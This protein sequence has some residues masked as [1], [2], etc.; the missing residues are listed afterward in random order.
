[1]RSCGARSSSLLSG[2]EGGGV[3]VEWL[4]GTLEPLYCFDQSHY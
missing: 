4:V 1:M 2:E 3:G